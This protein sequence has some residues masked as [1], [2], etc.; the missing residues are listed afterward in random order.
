MSGFVWYGTSILEG[1]LGGTPQSA[2]LGTVTETDTAQAITRTKTRALG[3]A[4]ETDTARPLSSAHPPTL[5]WTQT[6]TFADGAPWPFPWTVKDSISFGAAFNEVRSNQGYVGAAGDTF[7]YQFLSAEHATLLLTDCEVYVD[8]NI[9]GGES[10]AFIG[11]RTDSDGSFGYQLELTGF[12]DGGG[13]RDWGWFLHGSVTSNIAN[14]N[15]FV[16]TGS[17]TVMR[18]RFQT[19]GNLIRFKIWDQ[20]LS[21]PGAWTYSTTNTDHPGGGYVQLGGQGG[22]AAPW[23]PSYDNLLFQTAT[24]AQVV[25]VGTATETDSAGTFGR[26][27]IRAVGTATEADSA[28]AMT[29]AR[30]KAIGIASETDTAGTFGRIST[31]AVGTASETDSAITLGRI[32]T[33]AI[34]T[35]TESDSAIQITHGRSLAANP[36]SETDTAIALGRIST[37]AVG[38]SSETDTAGTFGR[39][40]TKAV[41]VATETDT[42]SGITRTHIRLVGAASETD[43]AGTFGR[44]STRAPSVAAETD[45]AVALASLKTKAIGF[46]DETDTAGTFV[47]VKGTNDWVGVIPL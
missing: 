40:T 46:G 41:S 25:A 1:P 31:R 22:V 10:T 27:S 21:E 35:A 43:T 15:F 16:T 24:T 34:G 36:A 11:L 7:D 20:S 26:I 18:I 14:D 12:D 19:V 4:T 33:K 32:S 13:G 5:P 42:A 37:R 45:A 6:W 44:V 38:T 29:T 47:V 39:I 30:A 23:G 9:T 17:I 2:A 28:V 8:V 3:T